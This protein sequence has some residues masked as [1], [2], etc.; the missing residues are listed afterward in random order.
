MYVIIIAYQHEKCRS[1]SMF[2]KSKVGD[3][4]HKL[5]TQRSWL[6][7]PSQGNGLNLQN[8]NF[9]NPVLSHLAS[10]ARYIG[11]C[12]VS[13]WHEVAAK[14]QETKLHAISGRIRIYNMLPCVLK[15]LQ[16]TVFF[17]FV[18]VRLRLW[19]WIA[20]VIITVSLSLEFEFQSQCSFGFAVSLLWLPVQAI[21]LLTRGRDIPNSES[22]LAETSLLLLLVLVHQPPAPGHDNPFCT[23]INHLKVSYTF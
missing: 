11:I 19:W 22:P 9:S 18:L 20:M 2:R 17:T 16:I 10:W 14:I 15:K 3:A 21:T 1:T 6:V 5:S 12:L 7:E 8:V 4:L 23:A 13:L